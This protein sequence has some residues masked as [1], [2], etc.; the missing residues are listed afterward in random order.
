MFYSNYYTY[1]FDNFN[2]PRVKLEK[3]LR[4][5]IDDKKPNGFTSKAIR[6]PNGFFDSIEVKPIGFYDR[7]FAP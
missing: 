5:Q 7:L 3:L 6:K 4:A 2:V 1:D